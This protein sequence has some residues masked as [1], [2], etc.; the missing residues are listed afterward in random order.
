[1]N[2]K[3]EEIGLYLVGAFVTLTIA[4][5]VAF[6]WL[7]ASILGSAVA[8][9]YSA[10]VDAMLRSPICTLFFSPWLKANMLAQLKQS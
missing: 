6:G 8:S 3:I 5:I 10:M 4:A 1:M 9:M 7:L 2:T